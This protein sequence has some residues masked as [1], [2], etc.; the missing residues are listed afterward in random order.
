MATQ[1]LMS[2]S[3]NP[4]NRAVFMDEIRVWVASEC[5]FEKVMVSGSKAYCDVCE[6]VLETNIMFSSSFPV[7]AFEYEREHGYWYDWGWEWFGLKE[8]SFNVEF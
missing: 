7:T 6:K 8:F 5:C 1:V 4:K 3:Q 2:S